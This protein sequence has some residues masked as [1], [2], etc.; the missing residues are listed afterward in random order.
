MCYLCGGNKGIEEYGKKNQFYKLRGDDV[1]NTFGI[2]RVK[3]CKILS[4]W[5]DAYYDLDIFEINTLDKALTRY[6][7]LATGWNEEE[8]KMHRFG[9]AEPPVRSAAAVRFISPILTVADTNID[10]I[11]KTYFERPLS[12]FL[13]EY[14][15]NV[16]TDC[17][18]AQP[19]LAGDPDKPYFF[20]QE[21]F[22]ARLKQSQRFGKTDA[23]GRPSTRANACSYAARPQRRT[24]NKSI[25]IKNHCMAA[26]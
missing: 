26:M 9:D 19:K 10:N 24:V 8:L 11:C 7:S 20:L 25:M 3:Q 14:H 16:V 23:S 13:N 18:I 17:M 5:L 4:D 6:E 2:K 15:I 21:R 1:I 22:A 12:G